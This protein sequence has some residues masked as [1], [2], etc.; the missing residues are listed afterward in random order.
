MCPFEVRIANRHNHYMFVAD[1]IRYG[2]VGEKAKE[3]LMGLFKTGYTPTSSLVVLKHDI[4]VEYGQQFVSASSP[5]VT[6]QFCTRS[7]VCAQG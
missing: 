7:N 4:Q 1:A 5:E 6:T 2:D 3:V